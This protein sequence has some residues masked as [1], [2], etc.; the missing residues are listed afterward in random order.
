MRHQPHASSDVDLRRPWAC[1]LGRRLVRDCRLPCRVY[2]SLLEGW[3][4]TSSINAIN[5]TRKPA[6]T[7]E[8][9]DTS[10][11]RAFIEFVLAGFLVVFIAHFW[12]V[13]GKK[14]RKRDICD[15]FKETFFFDWWILYHCKSTYEFCVTY[16]KFWTCS[17]SGFFFLFL[18]LFFFFARYK[19]F[20]TCSSLM[21][22]K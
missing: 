1:F 6:S 7:K 15:F 4:K 12:K 16:K 9:K 14:N 17:V 18:F 22:T 19:K 10:L 13:G 20:W 21:D 2:R 8:D 5:P 3:W 11:N